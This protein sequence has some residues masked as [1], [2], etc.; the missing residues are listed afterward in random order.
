MN[1]KAGFS[2]INVSGTLLREAG[3]Y[4]GVW[5]EDEKSRVG[6]RAYVVTKERWY[7]IEAAMQK[8]VF[9]FAGMIPL[10]TYS[11][12]L[13]DTIAQSRGILIGKLELL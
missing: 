6:V 4:F 11:K 13:E 9:S 8:D 12:E 10:L 3:Y 2:A 5:I 1:D 7:E